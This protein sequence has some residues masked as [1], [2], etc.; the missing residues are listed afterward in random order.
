MKHTDA[1]VRNV[2]N[3]Y[4]LERYPKEKR[5]EDIDRAYYSE[6]VTYS[7][8]VFAEGE[9]ESNSCNMCL[10]SAYIYKISSDDFSKPYE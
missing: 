1:L 5:S 10:Q 2:P 3:H 8:T 7:D 6:R 4:E 9:G